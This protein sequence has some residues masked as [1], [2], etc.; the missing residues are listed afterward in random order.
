[1]QSRIRCRLYVGMSM[2]DVTNDL[3]NWDDIY[4]KLKRVGY[5]GVVR[6]FAGKFEFVRKAR[7]IIRADLMSNMVYSVPRLVWY[8][9]DD[10]WSWKEV[11]AYV[12]D[13]SSFDDDGS[14]VSISAVDNSLESIIKAK[15]GI[16]YEYSVEKVKEEKRLHYDRISMLNTVKWIAVGESN[17]VD[18][19]VLNRYT[20][21]LSRA[22]EGVIPMNI[23]N[24]EVAFNSK[25]DYRDLPAGET[26]VGTNGFFVA[27]EAM[28]VKVR[29][30]F[31]F[32]VTADK[33]SS[34]SVSVQRGSKSIIGLSW[35][36]DGKSYSRV[37]AEVSVDLEK[38]DKLTP[39]AQLGVRNGDWFTL[40]IKNCTLSCEWME[41]SNKVVDIDVVSPLKLLNRLLQSMNGGEDG[42]VG[43]IVSGLDDRIDN[44]MVVAAESIRGLQNAKLYSSFT[45]F[46]DWMSSMFGFV[47]EIDGDIVRF[48]HRDFLYNRMIVKELGEDIKDFNCKMEPSLIYSQ[49]NVGY[50]KQDYDS[51]NGRDEFR[52]T[53][54]Y[55]TGITLTNNKIELIS[56]YRADAYGI[57]FIVQKRGEDTTDKDSDND[58]FFVGI[59]I[60]TNGSRYELIRGGKYQISGVI[61][62]DTMFNVMYSPRQML[63]ANK[64]FIGV[65][66]DNLGYAS[67]TGNSEVAIGGI[68]EK[69][70]VIITRTEALFM[71]MTIEINTSNQDLPDN[72]KGLISV[73]NDGNR[74][75]GFINDIERFHGKSKDNS[76]QLM[77]FDV[78]KDS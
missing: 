50:D 11:F 70:S 46:C 59:R 12:L 47:Y 77:L 55:S 63:L 62:P 6:S 58:V 56:P 8:E 42:I 31:L 19:S 34:V 24:T 21:D 5:G 75:R 44:C 3:I 74:Y 14:V 39:W 2:Y 45:K 30:S 18:D 17:E 57:E 52:F 9:R 53:T 51:V 22:A 16:Q 54:Q 78:S 13:V 35:I 36:N 1:M 68:S 60:S 27:K 43:Q 40:E 25:A 69:E 66:V 72:K 38:G 4:S 64:A 26:L 67:S 49:V 7:E 65:S 33:P 71:P 48:V 29:V 32:K 61:S 41:R 20:G 28:R 73:W 37:D 23:T 15:K 76:Y 10:S